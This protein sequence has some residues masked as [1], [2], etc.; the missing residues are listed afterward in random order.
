MK[1]L[2]NLDLQQNELIK[3]VVQNIAGLDGVQGVDGQIAYNTVDDQ[4]YIHN[5]IEWAPVGAEMTA[6]RILE[7]IKTVDGTG[8]G[9]DADTLDGLSSAAFATAGH[10]HSTF[11]NNSA[12]TGANVYSNIIVTD[13]I[14]TGLSTRALTA[15]DIGASATTHNHTLDSLSNVVV[16]GNA[17][18]EILKWNGTNWVNN[19]LAEAGI[20]PAGS[21]QPLDADLTS[22]AGLAGTSGLLKKTA[23]DTWTLD[24][25]AYYPSSNPSGYTTNTGTVTSVGLT[26]PTGFTSGAA[27]TGSGSLSLGFTAGYSLPTDA[28]QANWDN[29]YTHS[30]TTTGSVHGST[31]IGGSFLRLINPSAV[32]FPRMNAD[33]TVSAL[34]A[35]DFRLAIGA[36]T[37]DGTVTSVSGETN[38]INV[39]TGSTTPVITLATAYG[40]TKNP[41]G[42]KT[43][44]YVLAAPTGVAGAP[45][46]RALVAADIPNLDANKITSGTLPVVR[47]GTGAINA[48][49]AFNNLAPTTTTGDLIYRNGTGNTRLG[50]GSAGQI[51]QV[52]T[53][54]TAPEWTN[55]LASGITAT[56]QSVGDSSTK[57]ATTAFV[58]AEISN[59]AVLKSG[60]TMTGALTLS[61]D[62]TNPLHAATKQ[63]VDSTAQG[64]YV[65]AGVDL[66]TNDT[67]VNMAQGASPVITYSNG[68][69]GVG[70]T[71]T[72]SGT[73]TYGFTSDAFWDDV[74]GYTPTVGVRVL[75]KNQATATQN[76]IYTITSATVL[77]RAVDFDSDPD[78]EAGAFVFVSDGPLAKTGWVQTATVNTIGTDAI[79]F[80]QF[81]GAGV[82]TA[83]HGIQ[84]TG[85]NFS[86]T[87]A[88]TAGS[89][90]EG[91]STRTL[92]FGG[93]FNVPSF[94]YDAQGHLSSLGSAVTLTL[95]AAPTIGNGTFTLAVNESGTT[96]NSVTIGTNNTF[97][98]NTASNITYTLSVGPS[99]ANLAD[100]MT[101]GTTGFLKKTGVDT[102]TLDTNTYLTSQ[103]NDFGNVKIDNTETEYTWVATDGTTVV[104][105]TTSDT[106][107]IVASKTGSTTGIVVKADATNDAIGIAHADTSTLSGAQA[108]NGIA[109]ISVDEMGHVT[110][111]TSATYMRRYSATF[112]DAT[113][114]TYN[115]SH[116]LGTA[117]LVVSL[118]EVSTNAVVY[119]DIVISSTQVSITLNN[120]PGVNALRVVVIG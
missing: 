69:A 50:I 63:Y 20:Q 75:V 33:N 30:T 41:Y 44:N 94:S 74:T 8:S 26:V 3:A 77:T 19:T 57:I 16:T 93:T 73:Y 90:S 117:D 111:V 58:N 28:K 80:E 49:D 107:T 24:T 91:G 102:Y 84:L 95:P 105:D 65:K 114:L 14:V 120:A 82:Y 103:A 88:I 109:G 67:L 22:I 86:H 25:T 59:D 112:G 68:T 100:I 62:P 118:Y 104:A 106:L 17:A 18:G 72:L 71:L 52:N 108:G 2:T 54:G 78:I 38:V 83:S 64:L 29:S 10:T 43:A 46:F 55:T 15:G 97:S 81:S 85:N 11:D 48:T 98:A 101:G 113:N 4:L 42:S 79:V 89:I 51:L 35:S 21:Y 87:N 115:L 39:A 61:G 34:P 110:A 40:D 12:I 32:T 13:G 53:G 60:S 56:T 7:L 36:G 1:F 70:A 37:G 9:L 31:T 66:A 119:A 5:G 47:G 116:G 76:G 23:A 96:G 27:V 6:A 92:A 45:T 99:L